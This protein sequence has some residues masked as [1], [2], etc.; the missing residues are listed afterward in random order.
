VT[1]LWIEFEPLKRKV[2]YAGQENSN[3]NWSIGN[4]TTDP[5][6]EGG[7]CDFVLN[8]PGK[9]LFDLQSGWQPS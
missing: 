6:S 3:H 5:T 2:I 1:E 9:R 7:R 4:A 8:D